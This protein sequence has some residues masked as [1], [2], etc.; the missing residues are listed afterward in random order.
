MSPNLRLVIVLHNHQPIGNFDGVFE[1]AYQD[2]YRA[3]PRRLRGLHEP[4]HRPAH[5]RLADGMARRPPSRILGSPGRAGRGRPPRN[6]RRRVLRTD[7]DDDSAPRSRRPDP[8][9]CRVALRSLRH[10]GQRHVDSRTRLGAIAHQRPGRSRRQVHAARRLPFQ[11]R[12]PPRRRAARLLHH[13][14]RRPAPL[15]LPRQR[16]APLHDSV[17]PSRKRRSTTCG[18]SPSSSPARSSSSA[19]TAKSSASG[20][21]RRSTSTTTVGSAASSTR[22]SKTAAGSAS[23]RHPKRST[24]CRPSARSTSPRAATAK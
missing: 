17:P 12:R 13:R 15:R 14:E 16:A 18:R 20:P 22:S 3:F 7:P 8:P 5:Q 4:A 11:K 23:S 6:R 19:T 2:S 21:A 10:A 9:L 24:R 1:A